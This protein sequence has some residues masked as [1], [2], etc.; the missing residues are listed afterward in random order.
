MYEPLFLRS[1]IFPRIERTKAMRKAEPA[2]LP[3]KKT[4]PKLIMKRTKDGGTEIG[5]I[6]PAVPEPKIPKK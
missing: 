4:P 5:P 6:P 2:K 1:R 3:D